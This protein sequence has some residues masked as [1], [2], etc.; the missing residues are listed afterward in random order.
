MSEGHM[1]IDGQSYPIK[2]VRLANGQIQ[3]LANIPGPVTAKQG[4]RITVF[5]RD[6]QG[7]LQGSDFAW[8]QDISQDQGF[9]LLYELKVEAV[10]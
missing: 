1:I 3:L 5:G 2:E 8:P 7:V 9:A 4:L 6:G 10:Q